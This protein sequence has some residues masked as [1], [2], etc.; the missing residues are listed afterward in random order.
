MTRAQRITLLAAISGSAVAGVDAA[1]ADASFAASVRELEDDFAFVAGCNIVGETLAA[2][3]VE[4]LHA[5]AGR[6]W[7]RH[8]DDRLGLSNEELSRVSLLPPA[9]LPAAGIE[10]TERIADWLE[11]PGV[12]LIEV[13]GDWMWPLHAVLDHESL[14]THALGR[15]APTGE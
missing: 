9:P 1:V 8:F 10:E 3:A 5:I 15:P 12:R 4:R 13:V 11:Q 7:L 2:S 6:T 14:V